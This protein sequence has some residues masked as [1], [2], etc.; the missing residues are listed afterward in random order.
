MRVGNRPQS[1]LQRLKQKPPFKLG[2]LSVRRHHALYFFLIVAFGVPVE[3]KIYKVSKNYVREWAR[4]HGYQRKFTKGTLPGQIF[5]ALMDQNDLGTAEPLPKLVLDIKFKH[6]KKLKEK[7]TIALARGHLLPEDRIETK[8]KIRAGGETIKAKIRL[9]GDGS[10]H[11]AHKNKWSFRL[12]LK[13]DGYFQGLKNFSIQHPRAREY[14]AEPV[15]LKY[16]EHRGI[17]RPRYFFTDVTLNG[18]DLGIMAVEESFSKELLESQGRREG[19]IIKI[20]EDLI[21]QT[22]I[23]GGHYEG[24]PFFDFRNTVISSYG[25]KYIKK[26]SKLQSDLKAAV[27]LLRGFSQ[28]KLTASQVFDTELMGRFLAACEIWGIYHPTS[29]RNIRFYFNPISYRLEP[30]IYDIA[31]PVRA[32]MDELTHRETL[33]K[34]LIKDPI[35]FNVYLSEVRRLA[36]E[37]KDGMTRRQLEPYEDTLLAQ[38]KSEYYLIDNMRW[39]DYLPRMDFLLSRSDDDFALK[40]EPAVRIDQGGIY[41]ILAHAYIIEDA[42]GQYL[43]LSN[44][45]PEQIT[46]STIEWQNPETGISQAFTAKKGSVVPAIIPGTPLASAP[47]TTRVYFDTPLST[48]PLNLVVSAHMAGES[49]F[50][51]TT[52]KSFFPPL[53]EHPVPTTTIEEQLALH[54]F[55]SLGTDNHTVTVKQGV[56]HVDAPVL[57]PAGFQ[58][59][60]APGAQLNFAENTNLISHSAVTANGT[61]NQPIILQGAAGEGGIPQWQGLAVMNVDE[62]S[63]LNYVTIKDTTGV[64]QSS[65]ALTGGTTFYQTTVDIQNSHF[66]RNTAED[67]LNLIESQFSFSHSTITDTESDAIDS[68]FSNGE[69]TNSQFMNIGYKG[70]GD[71]VDISGSTVRVTSSSFYEVQDKA[72]SIGEKSTLDAHDIIIIDSG[73]GLA[74]KDGSISTVS[75]ITVTNPV[76][77]VMLA[78]MKKPQYG[79]AKITVTNLNSINIEDMIHAQTGSVIKIDGN[80]VEMKDIDVDVLY[81]TVMQKRATN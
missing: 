69:I 5:D 11:R 57:I 28:G 21:W 81:E 26:S 54:P 40:N 8:A 18:D 25:N 49:K 3:Q 73:T 29:Y 71:A 78:Y 59:I 23:P 52:A 30:V 34:E 45:V 61:T 56:W 60:I 38:L 41:P 58:L 16:F 4:D 53:L 72:L 1:F 76:F 70:G 77:A 55:L 17:L 43:E 67:A 68:D 75:D 50:Y 24:T 14:Q 47:Q 51:E 44:A 79:P 2:K 32:A 62:P 22:N 35:L 48:I 7:R 31:L 39:E 27:G 10:A 63:Q 12:K 66:E 64:K 33:F 19:V 6:F 9:K 46:L 20:D 74:S 37:M 65:W 13:K 36:I 42:A 15:A 80:Q